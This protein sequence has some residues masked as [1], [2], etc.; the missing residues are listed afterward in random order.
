MLGR[1]LAR[2]LLFVFLVAACREKASLP[3]AGPSARAVQFTSEPDGAAV[4][5]DGALVGRTPLTLKL[6][7]GKYRVTIRSARYLPYETD[8]LVPFGEDVHVAASLIASH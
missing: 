5:V 4:F 7:P 2:A 8:V 3:P 6:D 1:P